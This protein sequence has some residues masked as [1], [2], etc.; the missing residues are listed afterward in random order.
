MKRKSQKGKRSHSPR[1]FPDH[2]KKGSNIYMNGEVT[3]SCRGSYKV[4]LENGM[5][6]MCTARKMD[7]YLKVSILV[8]DIVVVEIPPES[9]NPKEKYILGR[10][11]W[12]VQ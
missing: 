10:I 1:K 5:S 12:R 7:S 8:G 6:S 2:L 11:V 4:T 3:S 9:L